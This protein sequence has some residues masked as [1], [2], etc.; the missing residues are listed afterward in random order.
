MGILIA[1]SNSITE[2]ERRVLLDV[3]WRTGA[4]VWPCR[5]PHTLN[6]RLRRLCRRCSAQRP[7]PSSSG[8]APPVQTSS[9]RSSCV[10]LRWPRRPWRASR[11]A[12]AMLGSMP[13]LWKMPILGRTSI[14]GSFA[15]HTCRFSA[16]I[17]RNEGHSVA[18]SRNQH[19]CRFSAALT[20]RFVSRFL[21]LVAICCMK[22][23]A[24]RSSGSVTTGRRACG[25]IGI[26][27][28]QRANQR[29]I[30]GRIRGRSEGESDGGRRADQ[31]AVGGRIRV[32]ALPNM[33]VLLNMGMLPSMAG[34]GW[35][36]VDAPAATCG[37]C[38]AAR[39]AWAST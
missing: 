26:E 10:R 2:V 31:R 37:A 9:W 13:I 16:A 18:I 23:E 25:P 34:G 14:I 1:R 30:R 24:C 12:P 6:R 28:A 7:S 5:A 36:R 4:G 20:L 38:R 27:G 11:G 35:I 8:R 33:A 22:E 19:T 29:A 32:D 39:P 15:W 3:P 21:K 17:D